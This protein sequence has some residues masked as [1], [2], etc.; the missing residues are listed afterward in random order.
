MLNVYLLTIKNGKDKSKFEEVYIKY[1]NLMLNRAYEILRD[2]PL[3]ED[4]VHNAF[5]KVLK[6][7]E[8][9]DDACSDK[10]KWYLVIITENEAKKIYNKE[11]KILQSEFSEVES[12]FSVDNIVEDKDAVEN[13]KKHIDELSDIYRHPLLLHYYN[14]MNAKEIATALSISVDTVYKRIQRGTALLLK[15][16]EGD[17]S[18]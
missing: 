13:I 8:K 5:L 9:I 15:K 16:V 11:H 7:L 18:D 14:G 6:N 4:A 3:A 10:T 17:Y 1:K 12:S 2:R